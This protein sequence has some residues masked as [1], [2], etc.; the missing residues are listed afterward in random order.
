MHA[1][2][3]F[4]NAFKALW[5]ADLSPLQRTRRFLRFA[6]RAK[7]LG[8]H[9]ANLGFHANAA[10]QTQQTRRLWAAASTF[11]SLAV[12]AREHARRSLSGKNPGLRF[13]QQPQAY[14]VPSWERGGQ[15]IP[16]PS[17]VGL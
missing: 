8:A 16:S 5:D 11:L 12:E 14:A 17:E 10:R 15:R 4:R 6:L 3:R 13:A 2:Q 1:E 7:M 9:L